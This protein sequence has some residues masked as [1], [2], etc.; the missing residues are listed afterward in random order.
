MSSRRKRNKE[1]IDSKACGRDNDTNSID[2]AVTTMAPLSVIDNLC[3]ARRKRRVTGVQILKNFKSDDSYFQIRSVSDKGKGLFVTCDIPSG[4]FLLPY[5][6]DVLS[7][8]QAAQREAQYESNQQQQHCY[9][10]YLTYRDDKGRFVRRCIDA[11]SS[12]HMSRLINHSRTQPNLKPVFHNGNMVTATRYDVKML[13]F[14][15]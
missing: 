9:M 5:V 7:L 2:D 14:Q 11:T 15:Q 6:G 3:D 8:D 1:N 4:V 10:F 12:T 13:V